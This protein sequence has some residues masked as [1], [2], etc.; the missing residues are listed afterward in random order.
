MNGTGMSVRSAR[1]PFASSTSARRRGQRQAR[2]DTVPEL[3]LRRALH[4]RG[5]R[6][7][8]HRRPLPALRR[9]ADVVFP[10]AKVAVFVDGCF[11][12]GCPEHGY[13]PRVN[14]WYWQPKL[15]QNR[16]R[17]LDTTRQLEGGGWVVVRV[18][19]HEAPEEVSQ[20]IEAL[21]RHRRAARS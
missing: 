18:W 6:Y 3:A 20:R 14:S 4:A 1:Q 21:V 19:E 15:E 16:Q 10:R 11:W 5:L 2:K 12:H 17:D 9:V 13:Q 8:V 7:L